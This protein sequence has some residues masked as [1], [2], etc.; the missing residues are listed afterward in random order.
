M[1]GS[2]Q[3]SRQFRSAAY[4]ALFSIVAFVFIYIIM[5]IVVV[6]LAI[7]V[8][9]LGVALVAGAPHF[10]TLALMVGAIINSFFIIFYMFKFI[11]G[12]RVKD[13]T[14]KLEITRAEQPALFDFVNDIAA[15]MGIPAPEKIFI[16]DQVNASASFN[17]PFLSMFMPGRR[18]LEIGLGLVNSTNVGELR[19]VVAHEFGHFQQPEMRI[20][21]YVYLSNR[22]FYNMLFDNQDFNRSL[23]N[24]GSK[25]WAIYLFSQITKAIILMVQGVLRFF[26]KLINRRYLALSRQMEFHADAIAASVAGSEVA[27]GALRKIQAG[28]ICY[29]QTMDFCNQLAPQGFKTGNIYTGMNAVMES[30]AKENDLE[31]SAGVPVLTNAELETEVKFDN[32]WQSHPLLLD[33]EQSITRLN[34][35]GEPDTRSAWTLV[36]DAEALQIKLTETLYSYNEKNAKLKAIDNDE[37]ATK[38]E[39]QIDATRYPKVFKRYYDFRYIEKFDPNALTLANLPEALDLVLTDEA[40]AQAQ[41]FRNGS[42]SAVVVEQI[43]T[44]SID[45]DSFDYLGKRYTKKEAAQLVDEIKAENSQLEVQLFERD[46]LLFAMAL[47]QANAE[48]QN[49][50][51]VALNDYFNARTEFDDYVALYNEAMPPLAPIFNGQAFKYEFLQNLFDDFRRN[52][53]PRL[54]AV[55][56]NCLKRNAYDKSWV[57]NREFKDNATAFNAR[58]LAYYNNKV[59]HNEELKTLNRFMNS[60]YAFVQEQ[61]FQTKKQLLI[62]QA[63]VLQPLVGV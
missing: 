39:A 50:L 37:F 51:K 47:Q 19:A 23:G 60:Q 4:M 11:F 58:S 8:G 54:K 6:C 16:S 56:N 52:T 12:K 20:G 34:F 14:K 31:L 25:H 17:K 1:S 36:K 24:T 57:K 32:Q 5:V 2:V 41:R 26:Y 38:F 30:F 3:V 10:I 29:G 15:Q 53:E 40:S 33:R 45:T 43:S 48:Q 49:N 7:M 62:L 63:E 28:G 9:G 42:H 44:G 13:D 27:A 55:A 46:K 61:I 18:N 22:L 21:T 59:F 35:V